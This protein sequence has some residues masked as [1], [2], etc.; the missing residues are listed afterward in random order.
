MYRL[1]EF[2]GNYQIDVKPVYYRW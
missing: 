2:F 1:M